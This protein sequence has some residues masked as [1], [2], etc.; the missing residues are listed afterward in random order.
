ME[1]NISSLPCNATPKVLL[2]N[3]LLG[4]EGIIQISCMPVMPK[5]YS[6]ENNPRTRHVLLTHIKK[7]VF[8]RNGNIKKKEVMICSLFLGKY[9]RK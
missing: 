5:G 1:S 7:Q 4:S 8:S 6:K 2:N 9:L 3:F